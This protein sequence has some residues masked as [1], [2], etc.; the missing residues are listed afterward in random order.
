MRLQKSVRR[1][2]GVAEVN[3]S[4]ISAQGLH[5]TAAGSDD[6][7]PTAAKLHGPCQNDSPGAAPVVTHELVHGHPTRDRRLNR[8]LGYAPLAVW[9]PYTLYMESHLRHH[10]DDH[11]TLLSAMRAAIEAGTGIPAWYYVLAAPVFDLP[12]CAGICYSSAIVVPTH[13][14]NSLQELRGTVAAIN[15]H[16]S[17]SGMNA[18]RHTIAPLAPGPPLIA[19]RALSDAQS[20]QLRD[21]L[22]GLAVDAPHVL[23]P[24]SIRELR[25]I[26]LADY[27]PISEQARFAAD[28]GY[29]N[30][31]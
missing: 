13:G 5:G 26:T 22:Q 10:N 25:A 29:P 28:L 31:A 11:L 7:T 21:V 8:L 30:L 20:T 9:F 18:L 17:H 3:H 16:H 14:A 2:G 6:Q 12:G 4:T 1:C 15:Q 24:L 19:S 27:L 23:A